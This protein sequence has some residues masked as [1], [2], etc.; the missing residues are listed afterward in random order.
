MQSIPFSR[1]RAKLSHSQGF[2]YLVLALFSGALLPVQVSLN[3]QLARSLNSVPLAAG[4]SYLAGFIGL[5]A[6]L[7]TGKL[8]HP[9]WSALPKT[10]P[11]SLMGGLFGA[12]YIASSAYFS[13]I[14]GTTLTLGFVVCGQAIAGIIVDHFGWLGVQRRRLT[15]QRRLAVGLL[16]V[17]IFFLS[18]A[19]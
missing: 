17:A 7:S 15:P 9:N 10:P 14:L 5:V 8:G 16:I 2:L 11:W 3:A 13:S 1:W 4:I 6:L 19:G 18:L 12:W